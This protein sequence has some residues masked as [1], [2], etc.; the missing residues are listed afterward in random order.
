MRLPPWWQVRQAALL[1][2]IGVF[3][4]LPNMRSGFGRSFASAGRFTCRSLR[5][6]Q[7]VQVGVRAS[8][9]VPCFVLPMAS[10]GYSSPSLWQRVQTA[11]PRSTR[12][13]RSCA[14]AST[15]HARR[16]ISSAF[17]IAFLFDRELLRPRSVG[18]LVRDAEVAMDA[19]LAFRPALLVARA[20]LLRLQLRAHR[21]GLVA[22]AAL[23]RVV[24]D[25][26]GPHILGELVAVLLELL[27][28]VDLSGEVA[29]DLEARRDLALEHRKGLAR[30]VAIRAHGAHAGTVAVVDR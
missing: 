20:R 13:L 14:C 21:L 15:V 8:A 16:R 7:L 2:S 1:S 26:G 28:G 9:V 29:P 24:A 25:H 12:S 30:H 17:A 18:L 23:V 27:L 11:S 5:P 22:I 3:E 4:C 19:G 10:T 6:W